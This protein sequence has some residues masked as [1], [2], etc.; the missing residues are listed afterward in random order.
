MAFHCSSQYRGTSINK[1]LLSGPDLTNQ[2]VG[3]L[4]RFRV[5]L[6]AFMANIQAIFYQVKVPEKQ[7][8]FL[9]FLWWNEGNFDSDI[10]DH[11]MC[12]H[13]FGAVSSPSSSNY[14]LR[15]AAVN[16]SSCYGNDAAA[17]MRR[18]YVD[19]LLKSV[20]DEEYAKDLIRIQKMCSAGRFNL[21][22]FISNNKLVL[23]GIPENHRREG[24]KDADLVNEELPTER[25]LGL[26]WNAEKD[27]FCFKIK[28][29]L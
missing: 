25:D 20:E 26:H 21:T 24:V 7:R 8:S 3:V 5:G 17:A 11:K 12:V 6:A 27:Q 10:T 14:A 9:R 1:N 29:I 23:M 15:K 13:L 4:I 19:D 22:K 16:N 2:P 28:F 18:F